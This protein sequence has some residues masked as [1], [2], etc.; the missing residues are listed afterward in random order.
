MKTHLSE[1]KSLVKFYESL[2]ARDII[3]PGSAGHT[4]LIQLKIKLNR[5]RRGYNDTR[6]V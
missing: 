4:R 5:K 2:L 3:T 1:L 6:F